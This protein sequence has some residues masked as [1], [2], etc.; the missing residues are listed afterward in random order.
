LKKKST[1]VKSKTKRE[2]SVSIVLNKCDGGQET[3]LAISGSPKRARDLYKLLV[4][5]TEDLVEAI[6]NDGGFSITDIVEVKKPRI[7]SKDLLNTQITKLTDNSPC[8]YEDVIDVLESHA[9]HFRQARLDEHGDHWSLA[10][11][12]AAKVA[13]IKA[14]IVTM[15]TRFVLHEWNEAT[16]VAGSQSMDYPVDFI[17]L[18]D[19]V[20]ELKGWTPQGPYPDIEPGDDVAP[21]GELEGK[22]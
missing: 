11:I 14:K 18:H 3:H 8:S 5:E 9:Q 22:K 1:K 21:I 15:A 17:N 2:S 12:K 13:G 19:A 10:D 20:C 4:M 16:A 7:D 6:V